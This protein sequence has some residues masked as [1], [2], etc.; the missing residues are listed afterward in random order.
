M[1]WTCEKNAQEKYE[2]IGWSNRSKEARETKEK[3]D[4]ETWRGFEENEFDQIVGEY[5]DEWRQILREAN[6]HP[7]LW[8][9]RRRRRIDHTYTI[10]IHANYT[11]SLSLY[12][13]LSLSLVYNLQ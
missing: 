1:G 6:A 5:V 12:L 8:C 10:S 13:S 9:K 11:L 3:M 7:G 2:D 4:A